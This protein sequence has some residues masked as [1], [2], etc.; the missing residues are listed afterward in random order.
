MLKKFLNSPLQPPKRTVKKFIAIMILGL[1]GSMFIFVYNPFGIADQK[2]PAY[3]N[4]LLF[5]LGIVF[6]LSIV[7]MEFVVSRLFSKFFKYWTVGKAIL[8]YGCVLLFAGAINFLYK[9]IL[10]GFSEFSM[11]EFL[12]VMLRTFAISFTLIFV[13]IGIYQFFNRKQLSN[14]I[15]SEKNFEI[16]TS[17][18]K[19]V[20]LNLDNLLYIVSD[21]NYVDVHYLTKDHTRDKLILRSSLKNIE[22]QIVNPIS[23]ISRCHRKYLINTAYF[24]IQKATSRS[25][26]LILK[27]YDDTIPVSSQH[28]KS[29]KRTLDSA[30]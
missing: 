2:G 28:V 24:A 17:D 18:G 22:T 20:K 19:T 3:I 27:E 30:S 4:F 16:S 6:A 1:S 29:I 8:W 13:I 26:T 9:N 5:S 10:G 12:F 15:V 23:P 21:D 14:M 11:N 7:F 25:M